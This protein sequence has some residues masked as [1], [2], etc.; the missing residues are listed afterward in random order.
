MDLDKI[1]SQTVATKIISSM[2]RDPL[3]WVLSAGSQGD[4][5]ERKSIRIMVDVHEIFVA[6]DSG[7][8]LYL[9]LVEEDVLRIQDVAYDMVNDPAWGVKV[10]LPL[11]VAFE[12]LGV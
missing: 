8:W 12:D 4:M 6:G 5:L 1:I 3:G 11:K 10:G 7:E 9:P 2:I